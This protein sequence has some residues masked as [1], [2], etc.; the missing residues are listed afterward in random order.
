M[1]TFFSFNALIS[2]RASGYK[3]TP[4]ALAEIIDNSFDADATEVRIIF[5]EKY[6]Q[7]R[8]HIDEI[9]IAD[10]GKGM[11]ADVLQGALQ[12][13]NTTNTDIASMVSNKT[14]GKFGYGLP[15]ASLSQ[16]PFVYVYSWL[17]EEQIYATYLNLEEL[18]KTE[19]ID[20]PQVSQMQMPKIYRDVGASFSSKKGTVVAWKKC[21]RLSNT[22][23]DTII[24]KSREKLGRLFRYSL[25]QGKKITF[26]QFRY[27]QRTASYVESASPINV[28]PDDP[29]YLMSNTQIATDLFLESRSNQP[30]SNS[31]AS[32]VTTPTICLST[33]SRFE[34][35]CYPIEFEWK[36]RKFVFELVTSI[37]GLAIQ[38]PGVREGGSTSVGKRYGEKAKEGNISFV[39]ADREIA[40]GHFGFYALTEPRHRWW[41]IEVRFSADSD[42]LLGVHNNKQGI[43]FVATPS[44]DR[45][46]EWNQYT[47]ELLQAKEQLW[48]YLTIKISEAVKRV[49]ALV[50]KQHKEWDLQN[51]AEGPTEGSPL[52]IP[53]GT[54]ITQTIIKD[55]DGERA[56][57]FSE[58]Q[59]SQLLSRLTQRYPTVSEEAIMVAINNYDKARVRGCV[60]Y[61]ESESDQFWSFSTVFDF[62]IITINT[63]HEFYQNIMHPLRMA[64]QNDA[65]AAIEL[66][67]S[68][69]AWEEHTHFREKRESDVLESFRSYVGLH[70]NRY[71]KQVRLD[72]TDLKRDSNKSDS[73]SGI[74]DE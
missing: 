23:S 69:L 13:G 68:S 2:Q 21:D 5:I 70:L 46:D 54:Q 43:E 63:K 67:V 22:R 41:T 3:S 60:L 9:L 31:Y 38:K 8:A 6:E 10:N 32:F 73:S 61:A 4:H 48:Q 33:N 65:L 39:R 36:G 58:E 64:G 12:F 55:T 20:I 51:S 11:S 15:N 45:E 7:G 47:A 40:A 37:T 66:F 42:D 71:I 34:D 49:F 74:N 17:K 26:F 62:L 52:G 1:P 28:I 18:Q 27:D 19:S 57:Q 25:S 44:I 29:L 16:C 72:E 35:H 14:K 59:K 53:S 50:K 56:G 30:W 24:K